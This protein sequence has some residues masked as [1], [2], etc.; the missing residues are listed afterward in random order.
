MSDFKEV[1]QQ[2]TG[3]TTPTSID[4]IVDGNFD[5]VAVHVS[6]FSKGIN[7]NLRKIL[8]AMRGSIGD[9]I[10][11]EGGSAGP[12]FLNPTKIYGTRQPPE[13]FK[14][15]RYILSGW[16]L[17][18]CVHDV[19]RVMLVL[20]DAKPVEVHVPIGSVEYEK[21]EK[22]SGSPYMNNVLLYGA[23][24]AYFLDAV[25]LRGSAALY[26]DREI[27]DSRGAKPNVLL[28]FYS[29]TAK[30]LELVKPRLAS[31]IQK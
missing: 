2:F 15:S 7:E 23:F 29:T 11:F 5:L 19:Y 20:L 18:F 16:D 9:I 1:Y 8:D 24:S 22:E 12:E 21:L 26:F 6:N 30:F 3:K 14:G 10:L 4:T 25:R 13:K 17:A 27:I 31:P 28:H